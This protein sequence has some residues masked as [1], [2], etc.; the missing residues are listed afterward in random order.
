V[1]NVYEYTETIN[2]AIPMRRNRQ[3][4]SSKVKAKGH[5]LDKSGMRLDPLAD[6]KVYR[7]DNIWSVTI[8]N[9][10]YEWIVV[11]LY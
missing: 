8:D 3:L 1:K 5:F 2:S 9:T 11:D 7:E 4:F 10:T 6:S